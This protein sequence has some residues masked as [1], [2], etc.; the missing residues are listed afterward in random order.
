VLQKLKLSFVMD[1][2]PLTSVCH[3][4][5]NHFKPPLA[6]VFYAEIFDAWFVL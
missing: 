3:E 6:F 4:L 5:A 1:N 2:V